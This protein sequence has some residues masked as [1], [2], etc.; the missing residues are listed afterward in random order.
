MPAST[1]VG[2][3]VKAAV[4]PARDGVAARARK[5]LRQDEARFR[6]LIAKLRKTEG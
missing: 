3:P 6:F 4:M 1:V 2:L 5:S